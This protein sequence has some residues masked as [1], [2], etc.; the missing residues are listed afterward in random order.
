MSTII[1]E[2]LVTLGLSDADFQK[3]RKEV[4][5]GL[6][7]TRAKGKTTGDELEDMTK[8]VGLGFSKLRGEV[9]GMFLAFAGAKTAT[10]FLSDLVNKTREM[11]VASATMGVGVNTLNAWGN[12][13]SAAGGQ[14]QDAI[15]AFQVVNNLFADLKR[16]PENIGAK[17]VLLNQLGLA[18]KVDDFGDP[19]KLFGDMADQY[20]KEMKVAGN[21]P[22]AQHM[23]TATFTQRLNELGITSQS[24]ITLIESGRQAMEAEIAANKKRDAMSAADVQAAKDLTASL[25]HLKMSMMGIAR[26]TGVIQGLDGLAQ[27]LDVLSG[28]TSTLGDNAKNLATGFLALMDPVAEIVGFL[29][30]TGIISAS[31]A[32]SALQYS[33]AMWAAGK[34]GL[35]APDA[36]GAPQSHGGIGAPAGYSASGGNDSRFP[37]GGHSRAD[38]NNNPGNIEDGRFARSIPGYVGSDGRFAR[39]ATPEAGW[40]AMEHLVGGKVRRGKNTLSSLISSWAPPSENNTGAYI[41]AVSRATGIPSNAAINPSQISSIAK[42]MAAHE[43]FKGGVARHAGGAPHLAPNRQNLAKLAQSVGMWT[44]RGNTKLNITVHADGHAKPHDIAR[45]TGHAVKKALAGN[46]RVANSNSGVS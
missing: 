26:A 22:N 19:E 4:D 3:R 23:V 1:D 18:G 30:R 42:A 33:P 29:Q 21:N 44:P 5:A 14:A 46:N 20:T 7:T 41:A 27:I 37:G 16:H 10:G 24:M 25:E 12:A 11:G 17:G 35:L 13:A 36:P 34:L 6:E 8:N 2:L 45:K 9:T 39:F 15:Q 31:T 32:K 28:S 40:T 43:G 38:R